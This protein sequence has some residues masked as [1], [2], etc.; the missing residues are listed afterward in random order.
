MARSKNQKTVTASRKIIPFDEFRAAQRKKRYGC[1]G[2]RLK[3]L[4][5]AADYNPFEGIDVPL[6]ECD[7]ECTCH[8]ED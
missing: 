6:E 8:T 3:A 5:F 4:N 7:D 1:P 2:T